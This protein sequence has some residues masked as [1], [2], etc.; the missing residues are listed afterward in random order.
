LGQYQPLLPKDASVNLRED[1][2]RHWL[3][4]GAQPTEVV[5]KILKE[6]GFLA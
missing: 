3:D 1:R 5:S 2:V 4:Q 6:K